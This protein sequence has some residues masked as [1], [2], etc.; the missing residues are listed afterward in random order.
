MN[1]QYSHEV[2]KL[3]QRPTPKKNKQQ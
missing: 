1:G 3:L 2:A